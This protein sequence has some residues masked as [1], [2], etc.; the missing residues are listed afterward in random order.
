[1]RLYLRIVGLI[2]K[3]S[4]YGHRIVFFPVNWI[5]FIIPLGILSFYSFVYIQKSFT[6]AQGVP[7]LSVTE[8]FSSFGNVYYVNVSGSLLNKAQII[9]EDQGRIQ[10]A[11]SPMIDRQTQQVIYVQIDEPRPQEEDSIDTSFLGVLQ[12]IDEILKK[13]II[14][15]LKNQLS[16]T[17]EDLHDLANLEYILIPTKPPSFSLI[18]ILFSF[19]IVF[20]FLFVLFQTLAL[21]KKKYI[22]FQKESSFPVTKDLLG[23]PTQIEMWASGLFRF[24]ETMSQ[25]L[26]CVR[27]F[28]ATL[29]TGQQAIVTQHNTPQEGEP[30][31]LWGIIIRNNT[32]HNL[33][34]GKLYFGTSV[35]PSI[36]LGYTDDADGIA[37]GCILSF[38]SEIDRQL[39]LQKLKQLQNLPC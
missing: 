7:H 4:L 23:D 33:T 35:Y 16:F 39:A 27:G 10:R 12:P 13:E 17:E 19:F 38:R 15:S 1:V 22:V 8:T 5:G 28:W 24:H 31:S 9:Q 37:R 32:I 18:N 11:W 6:L 2:A 20:V 3:I 29:D 14:V 34:P 26:T 30:K 21:S 36:Q 25:Y